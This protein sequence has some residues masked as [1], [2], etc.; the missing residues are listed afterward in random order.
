MHFHDLDICSYH[1][2]PFDSGNWAVPLRAVGWLEHPRSFPTG[3]SGAEVLKRLRQLI[4]Q[5]RKEFPHYSFRGTKTCSLCEASGTPAPGP[6]W[7]QENLW[8][9]G[10]GEVYLAPGGIMHYIE[11]HYYLPPESFIEGLLKCPDCDRP[12]YLDALTEAN[13]GVPPPIRSS[14]AFDAEI[15]AIRE[16]AAQRRVRM[17]K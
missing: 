17:P 9:P 5:T 15:R 16:A 3:T 6:V 8:V 7:S 14:E 2:G 11:T 4:A 13:S 1:P 10:E 12:A